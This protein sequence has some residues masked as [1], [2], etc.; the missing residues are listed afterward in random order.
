MLFDLLVE[1]HQTCFVFLENELELFEACLVEL[2]VYDF[3]WGCFACFDQG[4]D[5]KCGVKE[6][7]GAVVEE[8]RATGV[9]PAFDF[10][11]VGVACVVCGD[12][13]AVFWMDK[14]VFGSE[15]D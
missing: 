13:F 14:V 7:Q 12:E 4:F 10:D 11:V 9:M 2:N 8:L 6:D 15:A 5:L 1:V 3:V